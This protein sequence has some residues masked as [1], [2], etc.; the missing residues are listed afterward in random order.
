MKAPAISVVLP[1]LDEERVLPDALSSLR[2]QVDAPPFEVILADGGS[3]DRTVALFQEAISSWFAS[4]RSGVVVHCPRRGRAMQMNFGAARASGDALLFLHADTRL[5]PGGL[6]AVAEALRDPHVVAGGFRHQFREPGV[7][8]RVISFWATA[9]SLVR[10]IHY[11]D[12]AVF[13]RRSVF[14]G[15]GGFPEI[16]LF[17]DHGLAKRVKRAGRVITL[18]LAAE[19]SARRLLQGGV[20]RTG[21]QFAWLRLRHALRAD[22]EALRRDYPDVR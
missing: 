12:Q 18:T 15:V 8:L 2:D 17:E 9:R 11:G 7:L 6:Q 14:D 13:I 10:R 5:P 1:G 21:I 3:V 19:T 16:P 22:P 4:W 20:L